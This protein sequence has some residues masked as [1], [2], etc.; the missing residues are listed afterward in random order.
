[1]LSRI[2]RRMRRRSDGSEV[3]KKLEC[4]SLEQRVL[5]SAESDATGLVMIGV[6]PEI[7]S[8][9][10]EDQ[11]DNP[12]EGDD[13]SILD[14][15]GHITQDA[16]WDDT[17]SV[18]V[19]SDRLFIDSGVTLTLEKGVVV[20]V[21]Q[22]VDINVNGTLVAQGSALSPVVFTSFHDDTVG[23]D[24]DG[25][26]ALVGV[27][28]DWEA[29]YFN[30]D[31]DGSVLAHVE[32]RYAGNYYSPGHG[33]GFR[34]S[35]RISDSDMTLYEVSVAEGDS[36]GI[37]VNSGNPTLS[38]VTVDHVRH[39]GI[40]SELG[41]V[42]S[43][44]NIEVVNSGLNG[45]LQH[46]GTL[47]SDHTFDYGGAVAQFDGDVTVGAGTTLTIVPGQVL[48]FYNGRQINFNGVLDAVGAAAE[49]IVFT[50][51]RDDSAGGDTNNDGTSI[52][53]RG[54]WEALYFNDGS[55]GS[56]LIDVE[57][58]FAGNY[59]NSAHGSG[60]KPSLELNGSDISLMNVLIRDADYSG[61]RIHSGAVALTNVE[62][63]RARSD[64]FRGNATALVTMTDCRA[65]D[66]GGDRYAMDGQ[67]LTEDRTWWMGGLP[68]EL[69]GNVTVDNGVTLTIDPGQVI[70][71]SNGEQLNVNGTLLA[72]G[73]ADRRGI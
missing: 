27:R 50:S 66:T 73:T 40:V 48:K 35:I 47:G 55:D 72:E 53:Y 24:T 51:W 41:A 69:Y 52:G 11:W 23:G 59:Y 64:G 25:N 49:P 18:Y 57:V 19:V 43:Y 71:M 22:G 70:K 2:F 63:L 29:M 14:V 1:M 46:G 56:E 39:Q 31:S 3:T 28:G 60:F 26:G 7:A 30:A 65:I 17:G 5:L 16:L 58:R 34:P 36:V 42:V 33:N 13:F 54:D 68:I 62:V 44:S 20:K 32:V 10:P 9:I 4:E 15:S 61:I 8:E 38:S 21:R 45:V 12:L 67:T 6:G 37:Q